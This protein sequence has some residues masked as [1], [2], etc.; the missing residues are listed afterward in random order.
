MAKGIERRIDEL[1]RITIPMEYRRAVGVEDKG[2]LG[3][4]VENNVLYL[5]KVD[6]SF[7]GFARNVD[8]LGRWTLPIEIRRSLSCNVGQ[9]M[10]ICIE[11]SK[12]YE[13][14]KEICIRKSGCSWCDNA[15]VML[16]VDGH[17]ICHKCA[18]SV[19]MAFNRRMSV[20]R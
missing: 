19:V 10:D 7:V 4:Y 2:R 18:E 12:I 3:M 1:G 13:G 15:E 5:F 20:S 17:A 14:T 6:D 9:V 8:E 11:S 16:E